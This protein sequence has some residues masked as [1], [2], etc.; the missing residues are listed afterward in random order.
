MVFKDMFVQAGALPLPS[1]GESSFVLVA[2]TLLETS[3]RLRTSVSQ[4]DAHFAGLYAGRTG[5]RQMGALAQQAI[6]TASGDGWA[7]VSEQ[8]QRAAAAAFFAD[9]HWAR[10]APA[11]YAD[12]QAGTGCRR[13]FFADIARDGGAGSLTSRFRRWWCAI[14]LPMPSPDGD[15]LTG[16]AKSF[17]FRMA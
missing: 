10:V 3:S 7:K 13:A 2:V 12:A 11:V 1:H 17:W 6:L 4:R 5:L 8:F 9:A 15:W 14:V 16:L